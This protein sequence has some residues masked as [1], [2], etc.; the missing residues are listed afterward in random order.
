MVWTRLHAASTAAMARPISSSLV[1]PLAFP[2]LRRRMATPAR[3][4]TAALRQPRS[5]TAREGSSRWAWAAVAAGP[6]GQISSQVH[7]TKM[8]A[9]T[10]QPTRGAATDPGLTAVAAPATSPPTPAATTRV[11]ADVPALVNCP[12]PGLRGPGSRRRAALVELGGV[13]AHD[14]L[15]GVGVE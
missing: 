9:A 13:V 10:T 5:A 8:P 1:L 2:A 7:T 6:C 12:R 11:R 3:L 4:A 15:H 14:Q